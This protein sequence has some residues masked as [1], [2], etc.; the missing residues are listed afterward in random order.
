MMLM[1]EE[2][3]ELYR[4]LRRWLDD[5]YSDGVFERQGWCRHGRD[6]SHT[7]CGGPFDRPEPYVQELE[8]IA[9]GIEQIA[10]GIE[11]LTKEDGDADD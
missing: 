1:A 9:A 10:A 4:R 3:R 7:A 6:R 8:Q 2:L 5:A 11:R